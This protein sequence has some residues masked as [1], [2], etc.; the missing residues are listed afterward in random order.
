MLDS[1]AIVFNCDDPKM[2]TRHECALAI[3]DLGGS[4]DFDSAE[5][6]W[7]DRFHVV[8]DH[9]NFRVC[10]ENVFVLRVLV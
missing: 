1:P 3:D 5:S 4:E 10:G 9:R 6:P 2:R 7:S 8:C